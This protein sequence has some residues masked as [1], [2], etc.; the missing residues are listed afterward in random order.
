MRLL[1]KAGY[2]NSDSRTFVLFIMLSASA[3]ISESQEKKEVPP[4][5]LM[6]TKAWEALRANDYEAAI[7]RAEQCI[8]EFRRDAEELQQELKKNKEPSPG[9]GKIADR[10]KMEEIFNRGPLNDV[11]ACYYI[12]GEAHYELASQSTGAEKRSRLVKAKTA[13]EAAA[14]LSTRESLTHDS[15]VFGI[16]LERQIAALPTILNLHQLRSSLLWRTGMFVRVRVVWFRVL[17]CGFLL[18][19]SISVADSRADDVDSSMVQWRE[20]VSEIRWVG[21]FPTNAN[22]EKGKEPTIDSLEADLALLRKA[23]F[24]GLVTYGCGGVAGRELPRAALAAGFEGLILGIW[25]PTNN[26]ELEAAAAASGN[27]IVLGYCVGNEGL[28]DRYSLREL[29]DSV[30]QI[31][32]MTEKPVT[33]TEQIEDYD[34]VR[35]VQLGDWVFP[36]AH[37]YFHSVLDPTKAAEWTQRSYDRLSAKTRKFV[38]FKEVG[39]P[40][41]GRPGEDLSEENQAQYYNILSKTKVRFVYFEAFDLPWKDHLPVEPHWGL[42]EADRSPKVIGRKLLADF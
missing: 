14:R 22:P 27:R 36:N 1:A 4:N 31:R 40:T 25:D 39:L 18:G 23:K 21:Y 11:A 28:D 24:G 5:E 15:T 42:F 20:K 9:V 34:D 13:Y 29:R 16:Q 19:A 10:K 12:Q 30:E 6:T 26:R 17:W 7:R 33:T 38:L 3:T 35:L 32:R 37:P 41:Q 8:K 2:A